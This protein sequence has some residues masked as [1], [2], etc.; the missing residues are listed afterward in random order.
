MNSLAGN[1]YLIWKSTLKA[2]K[3]LNLLLQT[4]IFYD[5]WQIFQAEIPHWKLRKVW[6]LLLQTFIFYD[7]WQIWQAVIPLWKLRKVW[8][9]LQETFIFYDSWQSWQAEN[10]LINLSGDC[11][12]NEKKWLWKQT[13]GEGRL[14]LTPQV[15]GII[16]SHY[17]IYKRKHFWVKRLLGREGLI[18]F[19][20]NIFCCFTVVKNSW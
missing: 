3:S 9:L 19:F 17:F 10:P 7:S 13:D 18:E 11:Q 20:N 4:F 16:I 1:F 8:I 5:S 15:L 12:T 14:E 2:K 6:F